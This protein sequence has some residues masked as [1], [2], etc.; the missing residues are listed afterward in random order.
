MLY[1]YL[2]GVHAH[3]SPMTGPS[4]SIRIY[5]LVFINQQVAANHD[6]LCIAVNRL[7]SPLGD[8]KFDGGIRAA[9]STVTPRRC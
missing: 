8:G 3:D 2:L 7:K 4:R 6:A 9:G 5:P 1:L